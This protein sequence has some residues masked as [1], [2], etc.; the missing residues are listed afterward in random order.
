L[1]H[2]L[3]AIAMMDVVGEADLLLVIYGRC[4]HL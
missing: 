1:I 3:D 2:H 4:S